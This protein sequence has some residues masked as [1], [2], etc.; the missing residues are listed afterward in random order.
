MCEVI[1]LR[2]GTAATGVQA[3]VPMRQPGCTPVSQFES[4]GTLLD[5]LLARLERD[6]NETAITKS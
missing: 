2:G 3:A 1:E 4:L 6:M 5:S